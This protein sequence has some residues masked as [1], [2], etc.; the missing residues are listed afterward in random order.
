MNNK[1]GAELYCKEALQ[2]NSNSL[3]ALLHQAQQQLDADEFQSA[4]RTLNY[5][6]ERH[7]TATQIQG[8][9]QKAHYLLKRSTSKDYYKVLGVPRDADERTIKKAYRNLVKIHHP[10]KAL[11][12]GVSKED[13]ENKMA[14]INEA[15]EVLND[16]DKKAQ[17]DSGSDPNDPQSQGNPFHGSP[18][19]HG[20]GGQ[21]IFF[22]NGAGGGQ[23][24]GGQQFKFQQGG[25][26]PGF[27]FQFGGM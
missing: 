20:A 4:I 1:K 21:P 23:F 18:F 17:F 19:G 6:K 12:Q 9:L 15:Y 16:P 14:S 22:R 24:G 27:D 7:P 25:G 11:S 2:L 26:F 3:P 8:L 13:A 5:A 10:D